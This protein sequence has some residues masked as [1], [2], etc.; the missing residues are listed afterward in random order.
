MTFEPFQ[1]MLVL[2]STR[3]GTAHKNS[4]AE[5]GIVHGRGC[6]WKSKLCSVMM[7]PPVIAR[8]GCDDYMILHSN[9]RVSVNYV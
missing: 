4:L 1:E 9:F 3:S 7:I 2:P 6:N 5:V 8:N